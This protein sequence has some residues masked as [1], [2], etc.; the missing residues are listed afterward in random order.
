MPNKKD[1][2]YQN[3]K[4][5]IW[6]AR[7]YEES[8]RVMLSLGTEDKNI[9]I[10]RLPYVLKFKKRWDMIESTLEAVDSVGISAINSMPMDKRLFPIGTSNEGLLKI[11]SEGIENKTIKFNPDT[12]E[13]EI[14]TKVLGAKEN[15]IVKAIEKVKE[16]FSKEEIVFEDNWESIN[17]HYNKTMLEHYDDK[18]TA[19]RFGEIWLQYLK[20]RH[21]KSWEQINEHLLEEFR[22]WRKVTSIYQTKTVKATKKIK[23]NNKVVEHTVPVRKI[24]PPKL[25][26]V[27]RHIQYL[28][29]SFEV[30]VYKD[31]MRKNPIMLWRNEKDSKTNTQEER[32]SEFL[33]KKELYKVLK[34]PRFDKNYITL[35]SKKPVDKGYEAN[36]LELGYSIRDII[37]LLFTSCGRRKEI[38]SI[39]IEDIFFNESAV[40]Y[41]EWK[42]QSKGS[43]YGFTKAFHITKEMKILLRRIIGKRKSGYLF[44]SP[45]IKNR[46]KSTHGQQKEST[47][48]KTQYEWLN[49]G[50]VSNIWREV[51]EDKIPEK[52]CPLKNLRKTATEIMDDAKISNDDVNNTLGHY[53]AIKIMGYYRSDE[54]KRVAHRL[55]P[56]TK[57]GIQVLS[58][59]VKN[60]LVKK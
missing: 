26:T 29:K 13:A 46:N 14:Q 19:K 9:A 16:K 28:K 43:G 44:Q 22:S 32:K 11:F 7:W 1:P 33:T 15:N 4:T 24:P 50:L 17:E 39:K 53:N 34:D 3:P 52:Y 12:M 51:V 36:R 47:K 30:A 58:D 8:R 41:T 59:S 42:N 60:F 49:P 31:Y 5:K 25:I 40:T 48:R 54:S 57:P 45:A 20:K 38:L 21:I 27:N 18:K 35:G 23:G 37:L 2:L 6:Y 56:I 10:K 55:G